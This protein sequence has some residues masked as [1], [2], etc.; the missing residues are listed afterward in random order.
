MINVFRMKRSALFLMSLLIVLPLVAQV[1]DTDGLFEAYEGRK[2]YKTVVL[3]RKMLDMMQKENKVRSSIT[4]GID[5]IRVL[6]TEAPDSMVVK[7]ATAI[8]EEGYELISKRV[9]EN[10]TTS[11]YIKETDNDRKVFLMIA[12]KHGQ[13]IVMDIS[14]NF[15]ITEISRL[16]RFGEVAKPQ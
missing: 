3:G 12:H 2:G 16:S 9:E 1:T 4:D 8:A 15:N 14:G 5:R 10:E 11:F 7:T 13:E 6:S